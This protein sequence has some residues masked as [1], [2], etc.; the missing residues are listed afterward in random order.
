MKAIVAESRLSTPQGM[1]SSVICHKQAIPSGR[2]G[3]KYLVTDSSAQI[4]PPN[5]E[6]TTYQNADHKDDGVTPFPSEHYPA[7]SACL[8]STSEALSLVPPPSPLAS[9]SEV[10]Q[11]HGV[12]PDLTIDMDGNHTMMRP[13][14]LK[15]V[16][17]LFRFYF[18]GF[19]CA[20]EASP[21]ARPPTSCNNI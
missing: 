18:L 6:S 13:S 8:S 19:G 5:V 16:S 14:P 3:K 15:I 2:S 11:F 10:S 9:E 21:G 4:P 20:S 7:S 12:D 1:R 17:D